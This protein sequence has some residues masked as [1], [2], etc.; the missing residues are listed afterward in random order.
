MFLQLFQR[1]LKK[2]SGQG[3]LP[4]KQIIFLQMAYTTMRFIKRLLDVKVA[5]IRCFSDVKPILPDRLARLFEILK[6]FS[7][8]NMEK[9]DPDFTFCGIIFVEQRYVAYVLNVRL[10]CLYYFFFLVL[11]LIMTYGYFIVTLLFLYVS[12]FSFFLDSYK[13]DITVGQ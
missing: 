5:N 13:S 2:Q 10:L 4:E 1:Q 11:F 9:V 8:S 6:F 12:K 3:F 7:P